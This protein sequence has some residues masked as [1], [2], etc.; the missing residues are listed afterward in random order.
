M[1]G[2]FPDQLVLPCLNSGWKPPAQPVRKSGAEV[3][4]VLS[5]RLAFT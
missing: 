2:D 4:L 1:K 3:R 5:L